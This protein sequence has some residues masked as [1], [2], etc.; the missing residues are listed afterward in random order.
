[1][2]IN[3]HTLSR[4]QAC[5][6]GQLAG[7]SLGSLVE[8]QSPEEIARKYPD[9]VR[10]LADG[11]TWETVAGQPTDDS[12]MAL[13]LARMLVKFRRYDVDEARRAYLLWLNSAPFDCG[14]TVAAGLRGH[15]NHDSQ[16]NG[17]LMRISPLGVFC[18]NLD[19]E[20]TSE[21]A[22]QDAALTHP[23]PICLQT[24][25]LFAMAIAEAVG[26]WTSEQQIY[27]D[28]KEWAV[29]MKVEKP[30]MRAILDAED[31]RPADYVHQQGWVLI[32]FQNALYQLLHAKSLEEGVVDTVMCGGDTDT[33][34]AIAGA[35]LGA[36]HGMHSVPAQWV[37]K[38]LNCRPKFG[39]ANVRHPRPEC[40]WPVDVLKIARC[41]V[42]GGD[43]DGVD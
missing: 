2:F 28:I 18:C 13:A 42:A 39:Q 30:L 27:E 29:T 25:S 11:G 40:F 21:F 37:E 26:Q 17:A 35:L 1:M 14:S 41:L 43:A 5:L 32:A 23:H 16:A 12:E 15:P 7:D 33:N 22:R 10:E 36:V 8:F 19:Q 38:V 6:L 9:G 31:H 24:N 3:P 20:K 34:A 4:A